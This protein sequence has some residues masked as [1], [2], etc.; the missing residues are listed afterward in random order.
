VARDAVVKVKD[1][2]TSSGMTELLGNPLKF[3]RTPVKYA[4]APPRFGADTDQLKDILNNHANRQKT[5]D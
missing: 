1:P 2:S 3:S 5:A 4:K